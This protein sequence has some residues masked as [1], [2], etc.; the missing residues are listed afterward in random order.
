MD[1]DVLNELEAELLKKRLKFLR[2]QGAT[3]KSNAFRLR[4]DFFKQLEDHWMF[5]A[6]LSDIYAVKEIHDPRRDTDVA[7]TLPLSTR[8][9]RREA[10][11]QEEWWFGEK[12]QA[13][14]DDE[15]RSHRERLEVEND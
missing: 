10:M 13:P 4:E 8:E 3:G 9:D 6:A 2:T 15:P 5:C 11:D 7:A 14:T 1:Q 12:Y